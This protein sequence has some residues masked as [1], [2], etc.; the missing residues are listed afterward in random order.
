MAEMAMSSWKDRLREA[1]DALARELSMEESQ[2]LK[3]TVLA[4]A[5]VAARARGWPLPFAL[6]AGSLTAAAAALVLTT[7]LASSESQ[8]IGGERAVAVDEPADGRP[9]EGGRRQ[10]QFATPGGTRIIWV[11]DADFEVKGTLP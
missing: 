6:T 1:D 5:S 7:M 8:T 2:R 9:T 4:E 3:R 11:F 10:L